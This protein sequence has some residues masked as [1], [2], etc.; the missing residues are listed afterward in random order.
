MGGELPVAEHP[1]ARGREARGADEGEGM[2]FGAVLR[3]TR[4]RRDDLPPPPDF[5]R[6]PAD[7]AERCRRAL[8]D[9]ADPEFPISVMDLGLVYG[10]E[11]DED[12]ESVTVRLTFTATACPCMDFITWDVRERLEE[13]PGVEEVAIEVV[14]DPP[15]TTDRISERGRE[16]LA[17][18]GVAV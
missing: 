4:G 18:A 5:P 15:W 9:V 16:Q 2:N 11:A 14:W 10:V 12:A 17:R 3:A 13:E 1:S 8:F 7:L 6:P